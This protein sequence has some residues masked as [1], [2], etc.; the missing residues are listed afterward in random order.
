M[1]ERFL[2]VV[3]TVF[4]PF[5]LP[6]VWFS[7]TVSRTFLC[8]FFGFHFSVVGGIGC[9]RHALD[10]VSRL[11]RSWEACRTYPKDGTALPDFLKPAE[12][13][14]WYTNLDIAP[15]P[16]KAT[17]AQTWAMRCRHDRIFDKYCPRAYVGSC[18][19]GQIRSLLHSNWTALLCFHYFVPDGYHVCL[20][21]NRFSIVSNRCPT[22]V[23]T[24]LFVGRRLGKGFPLRN[25][26][27]AHRFL[28]FSERCPPV[29]QPLSSCF[30]D[31]SLVLVTLVQPEE[32]HL[33][34]HLS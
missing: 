30:C 3:G 2:N 1:F 11:L 5:S 21:S 23:V 10:L 15:G 25:Q 16:L 33:Y 34:H 31:A 8:R 27:Q 18:I 19:S 20:F 26:G 6:C 22:V 14:R 12:D 9:T 7:A 29:L 28:L 13:L 4:R 17:G 32:P 24:V